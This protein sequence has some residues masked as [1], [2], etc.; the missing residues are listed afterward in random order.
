M[1]AVTKAILLGAAYNLKR[2]ETK[3]GKSM[4]T[5]QLRTWKGKKG[6]DEKITFLHVVAYSA[7][8]DIFEKYLTDGKL[9]YLDCELD[10]YKDKEGKDRYQFIVITYGFIGDNGE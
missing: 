1:R 10:V 7:I 8:A 3:S 9:V 2:I 5:L 4:V 6:V